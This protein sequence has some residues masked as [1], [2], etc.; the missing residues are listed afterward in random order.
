MLYAALLVPPVLMGC[1]FAMARLETW[2][3]R[4]EHRGLRR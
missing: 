4:D 2:L 1:L 3:G